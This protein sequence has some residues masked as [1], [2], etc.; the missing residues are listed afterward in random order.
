MAVIVKEAAE[1]ELV[2]GVLR[3]LA[4]LEPAVERVVVIAVAVF[5]PQFVWVHG[6]EVGGVCA[7]CDFGDVRRVVLLPEVRGEVDGLEEGLGFDLAGSVFPEPVLWATAELE[8]EISSLR[9][10]LGLRGNV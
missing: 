5:A 6:V 1:G 4:V 9:T 3:V 2:E 10:Q 7:V 8:D